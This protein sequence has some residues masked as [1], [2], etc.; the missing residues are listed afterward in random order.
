MKIILVFLLSLTHVQS[1]S[2]DILDELNQDTP[3][4]IQELPEE[5]VLKLSPSGRILVLSYKSESFHKGDF[6]TLVSEGKPFLRCLVAKI[7]NQN[8]GIKVLKIYDLDI[9][10]RFAPGQSV[11]IFRGDDR[12]L[13]TQI[14]SEQK[15]DSLDNEHQDLFNEA[16]IIDEK[17]EIEEHGRRLIK[18]DNIVS[19]LFNRI[20]ALSLEQTSQRYSQLG[21]SWQYQVDD[22]MWGEFLFGQSLIENYPDVGLDTKLTNIT[23]RLKYTFK[24]PLYSFLQPY[25]GLQVINPSSPGAGVDDPTDPQDPS[26]LARD[27][28]RIDALKKTSLIFGI[29]VLKRLVPGWFARFD[30]GTDI[31][32]GGFGFE[33]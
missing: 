21:V 19:G 10:K 26:V 4:Q 1:F 7:D 8:S 23:I 30:L 6:I 17:L 25:F 33:F 3:V 13:F 31:I 9:W 29:T 15:K 11:K 5:T 22:N 24:A 28:Q 12:A 14:K 18:T 20:E 32:N 27:I 16:A 2:Q